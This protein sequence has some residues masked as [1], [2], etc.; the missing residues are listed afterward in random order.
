LPAPCFSRSRLLALLALSAC[1][2]ACSSSD[3]PAPTSSGG[4]GGSSDASSAPDADASTEAA[5]PEPDAAD[6]P[7]AEP[8]DLPDGTPV[9][10][11]CTDAFGHGLTQ[12][13]GRLDGYLVSIVSPSSNH[14]C[15]A[16]SDHVHLQVLMKSAVYD[17]AVNVADSSS[18]A[19]PVKVSEIDAPRLNGQWEEGWHAG[20][21]FDYVSDLHLHSPNFGP[22][23]RAKLV[24]KLEDD[25]KDVNHISVYATAYGSEGVHLVHR[26]HGGDDGAI[27]IRPLSAVPHVLAFCFA[28][29]GF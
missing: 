16:D 21:T 24:Q 9:R 18:A 14:Q 25:L 11:A 23:D 26:E 29:Q 12:K 3:G 8:V 6:D 17:V 7:V 19:T 2:T 4:V 15:N 10:Q 1:L 13:F 22:M 27:V 28:D 20:V 5:V